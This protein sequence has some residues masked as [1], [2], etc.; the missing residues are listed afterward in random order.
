[1]GVFMLFM[2]TFGT[3]TDWDVSR[4]TVGKMFAGL[5]GLDDVDALILYNTR[6]SSDDASYLVE[7]ELIDALNERGIDVYLSAPLDGKPQY[8]MQYLVNE[9]RVVHKRAFRKLLV[10]KRMIE[11]WAQADVELTLLS[12]NQIIWQK[13]L[14]NSKSSVFPESEL[15]LVRSSF[16]EEYYTSTSTGSLW[17]P[18]L[19]TALVATLI[20][21]FYAPKE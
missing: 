20:Y 3:P 11:R 18:V 4:E 6:Y 10:G 17:E 12:D 9:M 2:L 1:M 19:V 21:I 15:D 14:T 5:E 7:T 13:K 16:T 8:E